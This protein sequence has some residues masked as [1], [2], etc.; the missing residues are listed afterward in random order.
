LWEIWSSRPTDPPRKRF[1][2]QL[3]EGFGPT[4]EEKRLGSAP[5]DV[6]TP[7]P[8]EGYQRLIRQPLRDSCHPSGVGYARSSWSRKERC[9]A[10][11]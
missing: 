7:V 2:E 3:V 8:L 10:T 11:G 1:R 5:I 9:P 4:P 6:A